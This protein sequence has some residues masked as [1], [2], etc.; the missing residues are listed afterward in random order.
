MPDLTRPTQVSKPFSNALP[1][2]VQG[3]NSD[4]VIVKGGPVAVYIY[5]TGAYSINNG[6]GLKTYPAG[7]ILNLEDYETGIGEITIVPAAGQTV[8]V[9]G[10]YK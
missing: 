5:P 2:I 6:D 10:I 1:N 7:V 8:Q 3:T 9:V 4:P